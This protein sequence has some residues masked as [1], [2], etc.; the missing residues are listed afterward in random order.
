MHAGDRNVAIMTRQLSKLRSITDSTGFGYPLT[1][2]LAVFALT[3][4]RDA[5]IAPR[6]PVLVVLVSTAPGSGPSDSTAT[7]HFILTAS[8]PR[9]LPTR[10]QP[11]HG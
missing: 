11:V 9:L 4:D 10:A 6:P 1:L 8:Q 2:L 5:S 3:L 7:A